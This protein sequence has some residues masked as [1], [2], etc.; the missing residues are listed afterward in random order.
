MFKIIMFL[1]YEGP[2][3]PGG[4]IGPV[5]GQLPLATKAAAGYPTA[6]I[7]PFHVSKSPKNKISGLK[8][9]KIHSFTIP[10]N[11][12]SIRI[13]V[14]CS[15]GNCPWYFIQVEG[16]LPKEE[17]FFSGFRHPYDLQKELLQR[18]TLLFGVAAVNALPAIARHMGISNGQIEWNLFAQDWE[19][20]T[21]LLAF[22]SQK[23][24]YGRLHL[25]IHNTYDAFVT[26]DELV[27]VGIDP[28]PNP[29][30][31][32][33]QRVLSIIESPVF[34]VSNQFALDLTKDLLQCK[35]MAPHLQKMLKTTSVI[36]VDNGPFTTLKIDLSLVQKASTG[37]INPLK[38]WK[39]SKKKEA[40]LALDEHLP[41]ENAPIW[42]DRHKFRR[43]DSLWIVMAGRDD[44]RQKGY[45][46]ATAAIEDYLKIHHGKPD[47][48]QF[49]FFPIPGDEEL[50]GLK[51]MKDLADQFPED[52]IAFPFIWKEGFVAAIQG[53]AY[54]LMPSFYE[55]FGMS[56]EF[57]LFGGCV[58]IGRATGGNLLQIVPLRATSAFSDAVKVRSN[59][60]Y[61]LSAQPT[62]ILFRE[63]DKIGSA[64]TDWEDINSTD[65]DKAGGYPSRVEKRRSIT[66]FQEM[67]KELRIAIEDGVYIHRNEPELYYRMVA[68]GITHIQSTFSWRLAGQQYA[69]KIG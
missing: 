31:T 27:R 48:A 56:N 34:T 55:P 47:C 43:D 60:Y 38:K 24:S 62:G 7:T 4:G 16:G 14:L 42:G 12:E 54:G 20:A 10:Y 39:A 66:L 52:V 30:E 18:D 58:G 46:V 33:L 45:D 28:S 9:Q 21:T 8:M 69:R 23:E 63:K 67:S 40:L 37:N 25:T 29:K 65:Y 53:A 44:P 5:M 3:F 22:V 1:T 19:A 50:I 61:N 32:I 59:R 41:T 51:F 64:Q 2:S 68:H 13:N 35:I 36:G 26:S 17:P 6:V 57:Y 11:Q 49:L 15:H